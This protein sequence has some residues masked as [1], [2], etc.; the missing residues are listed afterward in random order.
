MFNK[1]DQIL[2]IWPSSRPCVLLLF[3]NLASLFIVSSAET[4]KNLFSV[5][6]SVLVK[7]H[8]LRV[9]AGK[10]F[11]CL[12]ALTV[13][14]VASKSSSHFAI[15]SIA[16]RRVVTT[17]LKSSPALKYHFYRA[18]LQSSLFTPFSTVQRQ[19]SELTLCQLACN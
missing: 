5:R 19:D 7:Y 12:H 15:T 11:L 13:K 2:K 17:I 1:T 3:R 8:L 18:G 14:L 16:H 4:R 10:N 9:S 6:Y